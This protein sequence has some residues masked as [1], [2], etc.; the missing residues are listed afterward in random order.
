MDSQSIVYGVNIVNVQTL[1]V[2]SKYTMI[3]QLSFS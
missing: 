3:S 2:V 1:L